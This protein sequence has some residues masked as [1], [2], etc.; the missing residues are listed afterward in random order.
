MRKKL[1]IKIKTRNIMSIY[2]IKLLSYNA[3]C[4]CA[5]SDHG[6]Y[7]LNDTKKEEKL[8]CMLALVVLPQNAKKNNGS[9]VKKNTS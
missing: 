8:K 5:V 7:Q 4:K 1:S 3:T 9:Y 6:Y 2:L